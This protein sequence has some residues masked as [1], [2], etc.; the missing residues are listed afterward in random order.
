MEAQLGALSIIGF[1]LPVVVPLDEFIKNE[2]AG[3]RV[4]YITEANFIR[5]YATSPLLS[6]NET[7][8]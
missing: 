2:V 8:I 1:K 3:A 6:C 7:S 5:A 4:S